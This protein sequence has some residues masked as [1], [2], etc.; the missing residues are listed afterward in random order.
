MGIMG[1]R[2]GLTL[3]DGWGMVVGMRRRGFMGLLAGA[4]LASRVEVFGAMEGVA[5]GG[6]CEL[7]PTAVLTNA[8]LDEVYRMLTE[9]TAEAWTARYRAV[10]GE[11]AGDVRFG[12]ADIELTKERGLDRELGDERSRTRDGGNRSCGSGVGGAAGVGGEGDRG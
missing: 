8:K 6:S 12:A 9:A 3:G 11:L 10:Y 5:A 7:G 1:R 4:L 2:G